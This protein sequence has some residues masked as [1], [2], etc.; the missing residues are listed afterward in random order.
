MP[1]PGLFGQRWLFE[2]PLPGGGDGDLL[3]PLPRRLVV[4]IRQNK[5]AFDAGLPMPIL[6]CT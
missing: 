5:P 6:P 1:D 4:F 3:F 2:L